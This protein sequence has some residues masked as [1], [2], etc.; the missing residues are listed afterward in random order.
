MNVTI[1]LSEEAR[2]LYYPDA[3]GQGMGYMS[4]RFLADAFVKRGHDLEV[5]HP[6]DIHRDKLGILSA[7]KIYG[8]KD[9]RFYLN[10][11]D[12]VLSGDVFFVYS[13]DEE[14]GHDASKRFI[15]SLFQIEKQFNLVINSAEST[16][17]EYKPKQKKLALPWIPGF[18]VQTPRELSDLVASGEKII[19]KP[20]IGA[21]GQG[22]VFLERIEDLQ[23]IGKIEQFLF[24]RYVPAN[25]ERRYIFLDNQCIIRRRIKKEGAPGREICTN[26]DL[27]EGNERELNIARQIV[28]SLGMF[29]AAVDFRGEYLLE[30]N[31][32]GTGVA[33]PTVAD[34]IDSYNLSD[35][36]VQAVERKC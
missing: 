22:V 1:S 23:K 35:P 32:S 15:D 5:A 11:R 9:G 21:C 16:S 28:L 25:E 30:I 33:P 27:I 2:T 14:R 18:D 7:T 20:R 36:I 31:G 6:S 4:S 24:E 10:R 3:K 29:Y 12:A 8:F 34:E 13:L 17:Y 26:V 19:A